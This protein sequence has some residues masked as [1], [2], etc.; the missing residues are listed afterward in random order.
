MTL[1]K[2]LATGIASSAL[3]MQ[4]LVPAAFANT[5]VEISGN[6]NQS[7][8]KVEIKDESAVVVEQGNVMMVDVN[9]VSKA[10]TGGNKAN[11]NTGGDVSIETGKAEATSD[12]TVLG[13][14]NI[15]SLPCDCICKDKTTN[16]LVTGNGNK[17]K[18]TTK[19]TTA[20]LVAVGQGSTLIVGGKVKAKANTGKNK[21]SKNT[22]GTTTVV[23]DNA[24]T[25][26]TATVVGPSN[27]LSSCGCEEAPVEEVK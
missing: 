14:T 25:N 4:M 22:N 20:S 21:A 26:S 24:T 15:A 5:T 12:L 16:V 3:I 7:D 10:N 11:A 9:V 27:T 8:N 17:S 23:T 6:G 1:T 19:L 2:K 18:N 13:G